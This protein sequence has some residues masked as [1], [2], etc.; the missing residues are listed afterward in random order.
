MA[1]NDKWVG[2]A[3]DRD[4]WKECLELARFGPGEHVHFFK[5]IGEFLHVVEGTSVA[6]PISSKHPSTTIMSQSGGGFS[7]LKTTLIF[8]VKIPRET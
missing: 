4:G 3:R 6:K 2:S 5:K 1:N 7:G 8:R